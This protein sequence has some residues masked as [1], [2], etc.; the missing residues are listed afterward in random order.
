MKT[1]LIP[2]DGNLGLNKKQ[3]SHYSDGEKREFVMYGI[4]GIIASFILDS[5]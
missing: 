1:A 2:L 4:L 3:I 5:H